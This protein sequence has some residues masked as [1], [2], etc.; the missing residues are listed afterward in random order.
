MKTFGG[1]FELELPMGEEFHKKALR[2]NSARS[3]LRLLVRA[4]GIQTMWVPR[5]TCPVVWEALEAENCAIKFYSI[6][7]KLM[8]TEEIP[9]DEYLLYT[10]YFGICGRNVHELEKKYPRM[11]LDNSQ[12][13]FASPSGIASFCSPRK[14]FGVPDGG[15]LM[16]ISEIP[17]LPQDFSYTRFNH[18][19]KRID[20][21][22]QS[23]YED[24]RKNED[25]LDRQPLGQ[26]SHLTRR[27]LEGIDY[28]TC[29]KKRRKNYWC[30]HQ[31]LG[32]IN[33][34][35]ADILEESDVPMIYPLLFHKK[36]LRSALIEHGIFTATYWP[37]QK[38]TGVGAEMERFLVP[39]PIDQRYTETDMNDIVQTILEL[40]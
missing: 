26:M 29:I 9:N 6:T 30:L 13:F 38:D 8:P 31:K 24:Y 11:I 33:E 22:A 2:L 1:Y 21:G 25:L 12:S 37:D 7:D 16:G 20:L 15:Y 18:L 35:R 39:L 36:S 34:F 10:N 40:L 27:L 17:D 5:F 28:A 32:N 23:G 19:L 3:C 14:F 4:M